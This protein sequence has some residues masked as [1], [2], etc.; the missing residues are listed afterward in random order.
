[1]GYRINKIKETILL[2]KQH[3]KNRYLGE[4]RDTEE[5][6]MHNHTQ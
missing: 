4:S 5:L 1:M 6:R 2:E 3:H